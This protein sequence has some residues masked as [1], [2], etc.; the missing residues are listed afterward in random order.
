VQAGLEEPLSGSGEG[1]PGRREAQIS[2]AE[3]TR[4]CLERRCLQPFGKLATL[5]CEIS[6]LGSGKFSSL[7]YN[8]YS[9]I[10]ALSAESINL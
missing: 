9:W 5:G 3:S 6:Q 8:P 10:N 1:S 7:L 2:C 4:K